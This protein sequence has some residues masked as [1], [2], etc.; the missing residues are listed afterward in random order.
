MP[1]IAIETLFC[2]GHHVQRTVSLNGKIGERLCYLSD[3]AVSFFQ[4]QAKA[5]LPGVCLFAK[6]NGT[7]WGKGHNIRDMNGIVKTVRLPWDTVFYSLRYYHIS[8]ALL[9]GYLAGW[10]LRTAAHQSV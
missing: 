3:A 4:P 8:Q 9:A 10:S 1:I 2:P 5:K 7:P 6:D